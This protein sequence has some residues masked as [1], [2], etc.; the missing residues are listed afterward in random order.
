MFFSFKKIIDLYVD[1]YVDLVFDE[2]F[3][4]ANVSHNTG[5]HSHAGGLLICLIMQADL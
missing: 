1:L 4:F 5:G 3:F 2:F